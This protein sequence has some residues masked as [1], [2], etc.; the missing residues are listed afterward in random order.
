MGLALGVATLQTPCNA[1]V[2]SATFAPIAFGNVASLYSDLVNSQSI[3]AFG[4][5]LTQGYSVLA[6]GSGDGGA[7]TITN[8]TSTIPYEVQWAQIGNASAGTLIQPNV[9]L[10]N[11]YEANLLQGVGCLLGAKSATSI[12]IVRA[13]SLQQATAGTYNGVL[14]II[15]TTQ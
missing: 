2:S 1:V 9:S 10:P 3:C 5:L 8:G 12:V 6:S 11:Q 15:L 13:S 4:S 14:T 7:F